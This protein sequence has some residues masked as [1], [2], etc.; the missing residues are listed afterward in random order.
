MSTSNATSMFSYPSTEVNPASPGGEAPP[1]TRW[2]KLIQSAR[3]I[4]ERAFLITRELGRLLVAVV[5]SMSSEAALINR[6][7]CEFG[8]LGPRLRGDERDFIVDQHNC[9]QLQ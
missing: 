4:F 3:I 6:S 2:R 5:S 7:P 9:S 1:G 8:V